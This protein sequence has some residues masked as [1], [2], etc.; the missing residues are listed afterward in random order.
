[1]QD[2]FDYRSARSNRRRGMTLIEVLAALV[3]IGGSVTAI[4]VAQSNSLGALKSSQLD[5]TVQH[6]A[7]EL[8]AKWEVNE[9]DQSVSASGQVDNRDSWRWTRTTRPIRLSNQIDATEVRLALTYEADRDAT[10]RWRR[11]FVWL[12]DDKK[13]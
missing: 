1:M 11:E 4:L 7:K 12:F 5:L 9:E 2:P 8:T 13:E 3:I 10:R 6:L